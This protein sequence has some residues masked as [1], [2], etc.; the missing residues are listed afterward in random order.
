MLSQYEFISESTLVSTL[1]EQYSLLGR[2]SKKGYF[3]TPDHLNIH[4][5]YAI[6]P[7][8]ISNIVICSGRTEA[9]VK[10]QELIF[11]LFMQGLLFLLWITEDRAFL[12]D[13]SVTLISVTLKS[14]AIMWMISDNLL[15]K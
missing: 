9:Y 11:E 3:T 13:Y 8:P 5:A 7:S 12:L 2:E 15:T 1:N 10:Y 4:Y 14:L 6:P